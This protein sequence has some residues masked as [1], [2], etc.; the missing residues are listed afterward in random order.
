[1]GDSKS[2]FLLLY[3]Y[4]KEGYHPGPVEIKSDAESVAKAIMYYGS[5]STRLMITD[6]MDMAVVST[7]GFMIDNWGNSPFCNLRLGELKDK[8]IPMQEEMKIPESNESFVIEDDD[9]Y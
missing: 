8:L 5:K 3:A 2:D 4:N 6:I 7:V 1:M 9:E